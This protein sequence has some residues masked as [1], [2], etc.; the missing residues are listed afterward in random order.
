[1]KLMR[2]EDVSGGSTLVVCPVC[3]RRLVAGSQQAARRLLAQH[4]ADRHP[5]AGP[6]RPRREP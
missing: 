1:M 4:Q 3:D 6:G 2:G 5:P